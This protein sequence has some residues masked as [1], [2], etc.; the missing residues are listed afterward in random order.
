MDV[1]TYSG[2][3]AGGAAGRYGVVRLR[4]SMAYL[5][6]M[7]RFL[8]YSPHCGLELDYI[9]CDE[10]WSPQLLLSMRHSRWWLI[11]F[12]LERTQ[13]FKRVRSTWAVSPTYLIKYSCLSYKLELVSSPLRKQESLFFGLYNQLAPSK[14]KIMLPSYKAT[15]SVPLACDSCISDVSAVLSTIPGE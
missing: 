3:G 13:I 9:A 5:Q 10:R 11:Q 12:Y 1:R 15:F 6:D 8:T 7:G 2:N 14:P 4:F